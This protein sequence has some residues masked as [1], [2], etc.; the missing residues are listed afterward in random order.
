MAS[1]HYQKKPKVKHITRASARAHAD[2]HQKHTNIR[3]DV[4]KCPKCMFWHVGRHRITK[5]DKKNLCRHD[6]ADDLLVGRLIEALKN[7]LNK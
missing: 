3:V 1:C 5:S 4:Y 6:K 7:L 2:A